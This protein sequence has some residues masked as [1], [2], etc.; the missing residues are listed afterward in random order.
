[1]NTTTKN[2]RGGGGG[3]LGC[4]K[5]KIEMEG[6]VINVERGND[7]VEMWLVDILIIEKFQKIEIVESNIVE[8]G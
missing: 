3:V 5:W 4:G 8:S 7:E 2:I 1:M 6:E